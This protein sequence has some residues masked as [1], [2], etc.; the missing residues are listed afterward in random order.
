MMDVLTAKG[1]ESLKMELEAVKVFERNHPNLKYVHTPKESVASVDGILVSQGRLIKRVVETK[2]RYNL[3]L[4]KFQNKYENLW[5]VT[6][7]KVARAIEVSKALQ[8]PLTGFLYLVQ[9][10]T[11]L[12]KTLWRPVEGLV[13]PIAIRQSETR[14]TINGGT[15]IRANAY[16]D[17]SGAAVL[18]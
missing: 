13:A 10:Q 11:L 14:E 4:E 12:V 9:E 8:V 3:G 17:M 18:T 5:L 2:C 16:I 6:F 1:Q 15:A 7:D